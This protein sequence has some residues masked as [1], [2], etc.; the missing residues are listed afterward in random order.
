M[1]T[2]GSPQDPELTSFSGEMPHAL[3][4]MHSFDLAHITF[5]DACIAYAT[6]TSSENYATVGLCGSSLVKTFKNSLHV[7]FE[8]EPGSDELA[9]ALK[10]HLGNNQSSLQDSFIELMGYKAEIL[11]IKETDE[12]LEEEIQDC[13][14]EY[15]NNTDFIESLCATFT[16]DLQLCIDEF[17]NYT[18]ENNHGYIISEP[19]SHQI[20]RWLGRNSLDVGKI[21][22]GVAVGIVIANY[23][24]QL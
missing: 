16:N 9:Q 15:S 21:S 8:V 24:R 19:R 1:T 22:A 11:D 2:G 12:E 4:V 23:I 18:R 3:D 6:D 13:S 14:M 7:I 5:K 17:I 10:T 20:A